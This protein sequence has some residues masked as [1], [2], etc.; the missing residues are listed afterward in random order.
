VDDVSSTMKK[1]YPYLITAI[2]LFPLSNSSYSQELAPFYKA[3]YKA[4]ALVKAGDLPAAENQ[5]IIAEKGLKDV[6][7]I[8]KEIISICIRLKDLKK[9]NEYINKG[10]SHGLDIGRLT[11]ANKFIKD[12]LAGINYNE[13]SPL[14][15]KYRKAYNNSIGYPDQRIEILQMIER[16][17]AIRNSMQNFDPKKINTLVSQVDSIN[18]E[19]LKNIIKNIGFPGY[20]EIGMDGES[21]LFTMMLH[22]PIS[23]ISKKDEFDVLDS[24][25]KKQVLNGNF[26]SFEYA[27]IIDRY[28][29]TKYEMQV[30]GTYWEG[31]YNTKARTIRP[32]RNIKDVDKLRAEIYMQPLSES[33][34]QGLVL[35]KGYPK[36]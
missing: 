1:F 25:I 35:P 29:Y 21:A 4:D 19:E 36:Q 11:G 26:G 8:D 15:L 5:Y 17:Q 12:Y 33:K 9:A 28:T 2:L 32:I 30:Y 23:Q 16:D 34:K 3:I 27:L 7:F 22:L 31:D 13:Y 20:S 14:Y 6:G 10:V 24:L 18:Y